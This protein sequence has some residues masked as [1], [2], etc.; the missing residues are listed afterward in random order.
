MSNNINL[1]TIDIHPF[2]KLLEHGL[3][4]FHRD[5]WII[6]I[7]T[8]VQLFLI[9]VSTQNMLI[10]I[11]AWKAGLRRLEGDPELAWVSTLGHWLYLSKPKPAPDQ[12][13]HSE[14][15]QYRPVEQAE[16]PEEIKPPCEEFG[17]SAVC[18]GTFQL[19]LGC[20]ILA[21][22]YCYVSYSEDKMTPSALL[23]TM[24]LG[25]LPLQIPFWIFKNHRLA[26]TLGWILWMN[27]NIIYLFQCVTG[28]LEWLFEYQDP[29]WLN[30]VVRELVPLFAVTM[31]VGLPIFR[32]IKVAADK[33][34]R[35]FTRTHEKDD[36]YEFLQLA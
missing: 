2:L 20:G 35:R 10:L 23:A 34:F 33:V 12:P 36:L 11:C 19:V 14:K 8:L 17:M 4:I 28:M 22:Y 29:L 16:G 26:C 13:E 18:E 32:V 15:Q 3:G 21:A 5:F 31:L 9:I 30:F 6:L 7:L 1:W 25:S 27:F 24:I